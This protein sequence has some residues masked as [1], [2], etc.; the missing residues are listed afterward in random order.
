MELRFKAMGTKFHVIVPR[1]DDGLLQN[2]EN[3]VRELE[4]KWTRFSNDSE[5]M[6]LNRSAGTPNFVSK[7][8]ALLLKA[9]ERGFKISDGAFNPTLLNE[10]NKLGY[11]TSLSDNK[12]KAVLFDDRR[13]HMNAFQ[14][15]IQDRF[16][17]IPADMALDAGGIGKG[18]AA[19]II[20]QELEETGIPDY[21]I[22]AGGDL[23]ASGFSPDGTS[24]TIK[25]ENPLNPEEGIARVQLYRG[26]LAT[27]SQLKRRF[28]DQGHLL[29]PYEVSKVGEIISVT[30]IA[31]TAA[32][33]EVLTKVPFVHDNWQ[34][35]ILRNQAAALVVRPDGS[36]I[37]TDNWSK[38]DVD[39]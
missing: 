24:W 34:E 1:A 38:Y 12:K 29:N 33:A 18:L 27:S 25:I 2:V 5:L 13:I 21:L 37:T 3:R 16:V 4:G 26:G 32:D 22:N 36:T 9:M 30:V 10:M 39:N 8:T 28:N 19:D 31:G 14:I 7:E 17:E 23:F 35:I 20:G 11:T 15:K 6:G